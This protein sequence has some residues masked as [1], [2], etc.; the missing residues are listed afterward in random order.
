[1]PGLNPNG[2]KNKVT[3]LNHETK[4]FI[5]W[6]NVDPP[7]SSREGDDIWISILGQRGESPN[8]PGE[9]VWTLTKR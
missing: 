9:S 3:M 2:D 8:C 5:F 4:R 6:I 7:F 1:M